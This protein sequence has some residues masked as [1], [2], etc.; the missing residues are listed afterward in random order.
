L[1][2]NSFS[3]LTFH[4]QQ[5]MPKMMMP[6]MAVLD[7]QLVGCAYQPPAGDQTCLG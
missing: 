6:K 4:V 1:W 7:F 2:R 5:V 3:A